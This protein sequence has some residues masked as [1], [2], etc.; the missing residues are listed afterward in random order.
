MGVGSHLGPRRD[1]PM[2]CMYKDL[3]EHRL[4][5]VVGM[6]AD[7]C[8]WMDGLQRSGWPKP[9]KRSCRIQI[10]IFEN[11][12]QY[13]FS[14]EERRDKLTMRHEH[15]PLSPPH[16]RGYTPPAVYL[17]QY[18]LN[19]PPSIHIHIDVF[20]FFLSSYFHYI[21][22]V[23]AAVGAAFIVCSYAGYGARSPTVLPSRCRTIPSWGR[24]TV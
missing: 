17:S 12:K 20:H 23:V 5:E 22:Q 19:A 2:I 7:W 10:T 14:S 21:F 15:P 1:L 9:K 8:C 16:Q 13:L 11:I 6:E 18:W 24:T 3:L 4:E